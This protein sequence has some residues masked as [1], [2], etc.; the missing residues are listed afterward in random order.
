MSSVDSDDKIYRHHLATKEVI[1]HSG[2]LVHY[3]D[4]AC[5]IFIVYYNN[6]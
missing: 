2:Y 3:F 1:I 5:L 6:K 4:Q